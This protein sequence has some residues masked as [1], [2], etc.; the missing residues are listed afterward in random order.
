MHHQNRKLN[1]NQNNQRKLQKK[2][3]YLINYTD[4]FKINKRRACMSD[5]GK[6]V[7]IEEK[8]YVPPKQEV[9]PPQKP[10]DKPAD[11]K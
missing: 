9:K 8:A 3:K 11:K 5:K 7:K 4:Y 10:P 2:N 6:E 1:L